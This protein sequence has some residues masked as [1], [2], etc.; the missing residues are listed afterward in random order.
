ML[1]S[2]LTDQA[3][4]DFC[5]DWIMHARRGKGIFL[6]SLLERLCG[7]V[8]DWGTEER[9]NDLQEELERLTAPVAQ[10]MNAEEQPQASE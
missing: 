6:I 4:G 2:K 5:D 1:R 8:A 10:I 7:R 9:L 3:L